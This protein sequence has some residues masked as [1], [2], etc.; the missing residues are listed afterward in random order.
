MK[1]GD[2]EFAV[3]SN[4]AKIGLKL[5]SRFVSVCNLS[6]HDFRPHW[7]SNNK[8]TATNLGEVGGK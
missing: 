6:D 3:A 5:S 4:V 1:R 2:N 8:E 7:L